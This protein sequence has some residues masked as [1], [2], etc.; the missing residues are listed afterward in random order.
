[1]AANILWVMRWSL[2]TGFLNQEFISRVQYFVYCTLSSQ[3][4]TLFRVVEKFFFWTKISWSCVINFLIFFSV[5][6]IGLKSKVE[7]DKN[8]G[9]K[10]LKQFSLRKLEKRYKWQLINRMFLHD[11]STKAPSVGLLVLKG[12]KR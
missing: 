9:R 2:S 12:E 7:F 5:C 10:L 3:W 11:M 1:M 6:I 4:K 8:P